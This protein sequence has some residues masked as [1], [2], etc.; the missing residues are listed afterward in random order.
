VQPRATATGVNRQL[1]TLNARK[2][3]D[4]RPAVESRRL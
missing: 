3:A 2:T 4:H 1:S